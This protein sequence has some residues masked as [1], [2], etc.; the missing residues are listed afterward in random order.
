MVNGINEAIDEYRSSGDAA[1][2]IEPLMYAY[3]Y[4][5]AGQR[6]IL[7]AIRSDE[8]DVIL[9][10]TDSGVFLDL[11]EIDDLLDERKVVILSP[12]VTADVGNVRGGWLFRTN[13]K[14]D[15]RARKI[16]DDLARRGF[17]SI[18]VVYEATGFGDQAELAFRGLLSPDRENAYLSLRYRD[19]GEIRD[20]ARK[21]LERRP[22]AVGLFGSREHMRTLRSELQEVA[23]GWVPYD[24][25]VFTIVDARTLC[26]EGVHF[27][28]L[29]GQR[30][31]DCV[32]S[33][34]EVQD[35]LTDLGYDATKHMLR[36]ASEV[37]GDPQTLEWRSQFRERLVASLEK[38]GKPLPR[39][40]MV[41]SG[42]ENRARP[43]IRVIRNGS[44]DTVSTG[45]GWLGSRIDVRR[46]R[47]GLTP[48]IN[49]GLVIGIVTMLS[50]LD[51]RTTHTG[52]WWRFVWRWT[53]LRFVL[54]N[55]VV[56][57]AVLFALAEFGD[58]RWDNTFIALSV[59][60]GYTMLLKATIFETRTGQAFGLAHYYDK[61]VKNI[62]RRLMVL[63]YEL[64]GPRIYYI[65]Y[66]NSRSWLKHVL[67][68][69]YSESEEPEKAKKL[70]ETV[71]AEADAAEEEIEKR[72][73]YAQVLLDL[74]KW[75]QIVRS[76]L[77]PPGMREYELFDPA[78][79]LREAAE[80]ST[81]HCP[82]NKGAITT[83]VER[84]LRRLE[85]RSKKKDY[86]AAKDQLDDRIAK[87]TS[88][89]GR[90]YF[91]LEWL[92]VQEVISIDQIWWLG[93]VEKDYS[94]LTS[95]GR[96][97]TWLAKK[98]GRER[99]V[100]VFDDPTRE[101]RKTRRVSAEGNVSLTLR[102]G[103]GA[104]PQEWTGQLREVSSGGARVFVKKNGPKETE[105]P[106]SLV[107]LEIVDGPLEGLD[108]EA[109]CRSF[110]IVDDGLC[111]HLQWVDP[112]ETTG[113]K[114]VEYMRS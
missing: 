52:R 9:G 93:F 77:V 12:L 5:E 36:V 33:P 61:V 64:E 87:A 72:R 99:R 38:P 29:S 54:F 73:V 79:L 63:R 86:K 76:R 59:A 89:R 92:I 85:T 80:Y 109:D 108:S 69:V 102:D 26:L 6:I 39:T 90:V 18:A 71:D 113:Q 51:V 97:R 4:E 58:A 84:H 2:N 114:I 40:N 70:I 66:A 42:M 78:T 98:L 67:E 47:F 32:A 60:F 22:G 49:L 95:W 106:G 62:N 34:R 20:A 100:I 88:E 48:I 37:D 16:Y 30:K 35:E 104:A 94:P 27:V 28:S 68:R 23:H 50:F 15:V 65:S 10:P 19:P 91:R 57:S 107:H 103:N 31:V 112:S 11:Q 8:V 24:P 13:V 83:Y 41:F 17:K 21:I 14:V 111:L 25:L 81:N 44:V 110:E 45:G 74:L 55:V 82:E 105:I 53:F 56:A 3:P 7:D 75:R 96:V 43:A 1:R 46:R 101:R